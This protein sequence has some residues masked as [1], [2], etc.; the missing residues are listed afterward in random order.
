MMSRKEKPLSQAIEKHPKVFSP[1][2]ISI[3]RA[4]EQSGLLDKV[5][6]R[7]ADNLEKQAKLKSTIKSAL[8]YPVIVV[9]LMVVVMVIMMVFVMPQLTVLYQN[10]MFRLPFADANCHR[11]FK[12]NGTL[13]GRL[14]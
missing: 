13:F 6:S 11:Y 14:S 7:L 4:G 10:L 8:M 1:I 12:R 5:L 2:Y 9:I 3:I